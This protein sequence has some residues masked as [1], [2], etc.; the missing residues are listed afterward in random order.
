[1]VSV[2]GQLHIDLLGASF[3]IQAD[4]DSSYLRVLYEHYK[5]VVLQV[6]KTSG[7][8]DPL[9]VAVIAGVLLADELHKEK[10]RRL[11][12]SE[13]DLLEIGESTE[14]MLESISKVV[15]EGFVCGRD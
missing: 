7:V 10:R 12:Q 1:M 6:E 2:K 14:R 13:E 15:D 8:R 3:S 4:E 9:K 11:V 5:M